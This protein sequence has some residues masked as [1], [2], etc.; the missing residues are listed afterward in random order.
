MEKK[1][2]LS[3]GNDS[4]AGCFILW[5][6]FKLPSLVEGRHVGGDMCQSVM[7]MSIKMKKMFCDLPE[8]N[9]GEIVELKTSPIMKFKK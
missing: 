4:L 5:K 2:W 1:F 6:G 3:R 7:S 8:I 9:P